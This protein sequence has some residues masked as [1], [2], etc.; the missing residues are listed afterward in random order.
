MIEIPTFAL[1]LQ[2]FE[3]YLIPYF[4]MEGTLK[5]VYQYM[6]LASPD[7]IPEK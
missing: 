2:N 3:L 4:S 7:H 6:P 1:L 5:P